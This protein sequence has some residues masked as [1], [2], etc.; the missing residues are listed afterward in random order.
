M[1]GVRVRVRVMLFVE[2]CV[3]SQFDLLIGTGSR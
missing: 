2:V 3:W 1:V